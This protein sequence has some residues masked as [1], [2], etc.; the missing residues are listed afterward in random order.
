MVT[1]YAPNFWDKRY[2]ESGYAYGTHPNQFLAEQQQHLSPGMQA[3]TV[4]DGEGRNGV[5]LSSQGLNVLSVD[6][7]QVGLQKAQSLASQRQVKLETQCVDLTTWD[8]PVATYDVVVSI[9]VHFAPDVRARMHHS[10]LK[11]LKPGGLIILEAFNSG[12]LKYQAEH[13]SGG[14]K[15]PEM[16]YSPELLKEDFA[17]G[18]ILEHTEAITML[19]EGAYHEGKASVIRL[20]LQKDAKG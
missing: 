10:M 20:V 6:L 13:D 15:K 17:G 1:N 9:Y 19:E 18:N 12:Q 16:L 7:S 11:S 14:P 5:W 4:G 2:G 8:W 3:L